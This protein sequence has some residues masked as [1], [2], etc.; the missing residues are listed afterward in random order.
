[1]LHSHTVKPDRP[2]NLSLK[3]DNSDESLNITV[4]WEPPTNLEQFDLDYYTV[5]VTSNS[6]IYESRQVTASTTIW[7]FTDPKMQRTVFN[8]TVTATNKCG[9]TGS[10]A[11]E[12]RNIRP[13][14][15]YVVIIV[16]DQFKFIFVNPII[17]KAVALIIFE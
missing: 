11:S 14:K 8:V 13:S 12:T 17:L 15:Y 3:F 6:S 16:I 5:N 4:M 10:T 1:M 7:Q 2:Q 9:Q